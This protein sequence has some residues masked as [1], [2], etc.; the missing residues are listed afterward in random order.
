MVDRLVRSY[1]PTVN[2]EHCDERCGRSVSSAWLTGSSSRAWSVVLATVGL[3]T[4]AYLT[5]LSFHGPEL[6]IAW[7][8]EAVALAGIAR[9]AGD[10]VAAIASLTFLA[11]AAI[12]S[13]AVEAPPRALALGVPDIAAAVVAVG[14]C[15]VAS[16]MVAHARLAVGGRETVR[17]LIGAAS[18]A[19]LYLA[20]IAIVG[21]F[22]HQ[23]QMLLSC[24]WALAGV[25]ALILGLRRDQ[26]VLRLGALG[27]LVITAAKV[28]LYDLATLDSGYRIGSFIV[29]GLLL[30]LAA[31][32][33]QRLRPPSATA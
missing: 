29:L 22:R 3:G 4:T 6:V 9:R 14:A 31:Y 8:G 24:L 17:P 11:G 10:G 33:Y 7:A 16:L 23:G 19:L 21:A 5:A 27:L 32:A 12:H 13:L 25:S 20:S 28:F 26:R 30:L 18:L 1:Q 15:A 2:K